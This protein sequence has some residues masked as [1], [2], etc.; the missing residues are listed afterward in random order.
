MATNRKVVRRTLSLEKEAGM[1]KNVDAGISRLP[2]AAMRKARMMT[3]ERI[4]ALLGVNQGAVSKLEMRSDMYLS[5]L[6]SYIEALGG[7]LDL[8]AVFPEGEVALEHL[9]DAD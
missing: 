4:A 1:K 6:R 8:R 2:L 7:Y 5:T 9:A 3:Q